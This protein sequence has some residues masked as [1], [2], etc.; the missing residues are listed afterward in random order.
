MSQKNP[1]RLDRV[2]ALIRVN[3]LQAADMKFKD[4]SGLTAAGLAAAAGLDRANVSKELNRLYRQGLV[5][6]CQGKPTLFLHRSALSSAF[7]HVFFPSTIPCGEHLADY[8]AAQSS[9]Q[10][11]GHRAAGGLESVIG[12]SGSMKQ[13]VMQARAA[14]LYPPRGIHTLITGKAGIGKLRFAQSM[15]E[16]A[17]SCNHVAPDGKFV[18]LNCQDY[19]GSPQVLMAQ[20]FGYGKNYLPGAEKGRYGLIEQAKGG[21]LCLNGVH[22]LS[23]KVQELLTTLIEKNTFC[24]MG[25]SSVV[26]E[27]ETMIIA[28]TTEPAGSPSIERFVR[29]MPMLIALPDLA[30]RGP[31]ELLEHLAL[32]FSREAAHIQ[33]PFRI[34]RD[35]LSCLLQAPYPG[36]IGELKGCVKGISSLAYLDYMTG[37][38]PSSAIE[39]S[40][41]HLPPTVADAAL[42]DGEKTLQ[43]QRLLGRLRGEYLTF[44]PGE[45]PQLPLCNL[46][47]EDGLE[48]EPFLCAGEEPLQI[49]DV[50]SYINRCID[51]IQRAPSAGAAQICASFPDFL[52]RAVDQVLDTA[53]RYRAALENPKLY[54]GFL[55]HLHSALR[56]QDEQLPPPAAPTRP[57]DIRRANPQEYGLARKLQA[58]L[59]ESGREPLPD[60]E[61]GFIAMYLYL[62]VNW[63]AD[64]NVQFL[65]VFHGQGVS[66]GIADFLNSAVRLPLV[67]PIDCG[68]GT[69]VAQVLE[70]AAAV[71]QSVDHSAGLLIFTDMAPF[72][73]L[74]HHLTELTGIRTERLA[75]ASM[76]LMLRMVEKSA[77]EHASLIALMSEAPGAEPQDQ[78]V[79]GAVTS[80]FL[81]R[82]IHEILSPS[83]TF[84]NP[85]KAADALLNVLHNT[86][87]DLSLGYSD[88]IA[89]KF[90]FHSAHMLER[91][92]KGEP[93]KYPRLKAFINAHA[94]LMACL[95]QHLVYAEEVF[96]VPV[97]A[98]EKAYIGEIFLPF[99]EETGGV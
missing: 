2:L 76:P 30:D 50:G 23:P 41:R 97:P 92:I 29:N 77:N 48:G 10:S 36:Q 72:T 89:V 28:T 90:I 96:G 35:V 9:A 52:R 44:S 95:D 86:L 3:T 18:I 66:R 64:S 27:G 65:A 56:R 61:L 83:L 85:G 68:P 13:A 51:R 20:I 40:Y 7:P 16:F 81:N 45:Q 26:R 75:G 53:P 91:V 46:M 21:I 34:H 80:S 62:A 42:P 37:G 32:F 14:V 93:L 4:S 19:S 54:Y 5:I 94:S 71:A 38:R 8:L 69:S 70:Q 12:S 82:I 63:T 22:K 73:D 99:M 15:Y 98:A 49:A 60:S 55:L 11:S 67:H 59:A 43:I 79:S 47:P 33:I 6:K 1:R 25:E 57:D 84:L 74:N 58:A 24:R 87:A 31:A 88:E 17:R 78:P 39:I